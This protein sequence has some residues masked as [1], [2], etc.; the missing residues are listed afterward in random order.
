M[1][2]CLTHTCVRTL[3]QDHG[4]VPP[5]A[6]VGR[7]T[8]LQHSSRWAQVQRVHAQRKVLRGHW[9]G[10]HNYESGLRAALWYVVRRN[11]G[12]W[13]RALVASRPYARAC[14]IGFRLGGRE[15][16]ARLHNAVY[17]SM[18]VHLT[19]TPHSKWLPLAAAIGHK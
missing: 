7:N 3:Q 13:W 19:R 17:C 8:N 1:A 12:A 2:V 18:Y 11:L 5:P 16:A 9:R 14:A 10:A 6:V 4:R 15:R